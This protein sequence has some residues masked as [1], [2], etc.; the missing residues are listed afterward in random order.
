MSDLTK[1]LKLLQHRRPQE[2]PPES[3]RFTLTLTRL[4][5][6]GNPVSAQQLAEMLGDPVEFIITAF[7]QMHQNGAEFNANGELIGAALTLTPY[8][9]SS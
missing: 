3:A 9:A 8:S 7:Q 2:I 4:L 1:T 5:S 6:E